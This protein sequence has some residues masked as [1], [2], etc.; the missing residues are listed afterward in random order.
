MVSLVVFNC[1][2]VIV[3]LLINLRIFELAHR[4]RTAARVLHHINVAILGLFVI[5]MAA[6][7]VATGT[8]F[9]KHRMEMFDLVVVVVAFTL[10][11]TLTNRGDNAAHG[12]SLLVMLRLWRV[13]KILN[14]K[15]LNHSCA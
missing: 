4:D 8:R 13:T 10:G 15:L 6:K 9:L 7:V 14:S 12:V 2:V 1:L 3:E 5:E 11:L